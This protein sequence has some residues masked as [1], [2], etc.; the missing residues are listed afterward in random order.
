MATDIV[1]RLL[2]ITRWQVSFA[3]EAAEAAAEIERLRAA[4]DA[5][6]AAIRNHDLREEHICVWEE[7]RRG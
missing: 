1:K 3:A 6:H 4:G 5:L 7:A 2:F